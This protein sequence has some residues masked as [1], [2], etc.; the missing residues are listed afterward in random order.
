MIIL[1]RC[2]EKQR[3]STSEALYFLV[4]TWKMRTKAELIFLALKPDL[5][6]LIRPSEK[7]F[8]DNLHVVEA[9]S[10]LILDATGKQDH[11]KTDGFQV[12]WLPSKWV[13]WNDGI[14]WP[15]LMRVDY[16]F[17]A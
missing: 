6:M 13:S 4:F 2:G 12:V 11:S 10:V 15:L 1:V 7:P 17:Y 16:G 8:L 5:F 14:S 9:K 3:I